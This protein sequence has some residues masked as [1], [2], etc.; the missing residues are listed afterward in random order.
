MAVQ[1]VVRNRECSQK[2]K[3]LR[4]QPVSMGKW[5][6]S[7]YFIIIIIKELRVQA[8]ARRNESAASHTSNSWCKNVIFFL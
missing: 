4:V 8:L 1:P 5:E 2:H 3:G 7:K 6:C